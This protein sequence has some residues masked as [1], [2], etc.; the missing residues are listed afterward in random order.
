[1]QGQWSHDYDMQHHEYTPPPP[2]AEYPLLS[3]DVM[4]E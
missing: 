1:M 4:V 3:V 2:N